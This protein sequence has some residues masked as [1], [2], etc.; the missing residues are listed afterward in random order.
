[1]LTGTLSSMTREQAQEEIAAA[2]KLKEVAAEVKSAGFRDILLLGMGGSSL[3]PEVLASTFGR[4]PGYP[5]LLV[6]D[7][8]DPAQIQASAVAAATRRVPCSACAARTFR[9]C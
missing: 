2:A 4:Q 1:M 3:C 6:L 9:R 5:E 7:S 8:T